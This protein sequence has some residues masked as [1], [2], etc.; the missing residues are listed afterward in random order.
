M[1]KA[2]LTTRIKRAAKALAAFVTPGLVLLGSAV[3]DASDGGT[4]I[5]RSELVTALTAMFVT[6][7]VVYNVRNGKSPNPR[8]STPDV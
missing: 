8:T 5:T 3:V 6:S 7:G 2:K 1:V 4:D